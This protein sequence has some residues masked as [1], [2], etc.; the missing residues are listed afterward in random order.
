VSAATGEGLKELVY[1]V[2]RV[3]QTVPEDIHV[4]EVP[5]DQVKVT[6]VE[7]EISFYVKKDGMYFMF[8]VMK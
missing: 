3:L 5:E 4:E 1:H 8:L 6:K 7:E 2:Y